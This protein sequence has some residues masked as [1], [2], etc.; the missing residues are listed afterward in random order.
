[1]K[2]WRRLYRTVLCMSVALT[3]KGVK[4]PFNHSVQV[5]SITGNRRK[6]MHTTSSNFIV[7]RCSMKLL[8][9]LAS[10]SG[11]SSYVIYVMYVCMYVSMCVCMYVC[12]Y[13]GM[14]V[15]VGVSVNSA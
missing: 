11:S 10:I 1:M 4:F 13:A 6:Q 8:E 2:E 7:L 3:R 12:V 14:C 5:K 15:Y 9:Y